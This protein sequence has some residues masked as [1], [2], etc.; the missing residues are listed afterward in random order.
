MSSPIRT[1]AKPDI[2]IVVVTYNSG[3]YIRLF[4]ACIRE[5]TG[6]NYRLH[7]VD[8]YSQDESRNYATIQNYQN[9]G[10]ALA[11]NQGAA[12]GSAPVICFFNPDVIVGKLW[13]DTMW[14]TLHDPA[15]NV[16]VVGPTLVNEK[17]EYWGPYDSFMPG[18][19]LMVK[20]TVFEELGGF[21]PEYYFGGEDNEFF[22]R[23]K[24]AGYSWMRVDTRILHFGGATIY[25]NTYSQAA[26]ER[27][28]D[29][30]MAD[31]GVQL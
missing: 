16:H 22:Y 29:L 17:A 21:D 19:C 5:N 14:A 24:L 10:F 18:C 7:Y 6:L 23:L 31:H 1:T 11:A 12:A 13:H 27:A 2:D 15:Q 3:K 28:S 20:R 25:R 26:F 9:V 30:L 4:D 8:N